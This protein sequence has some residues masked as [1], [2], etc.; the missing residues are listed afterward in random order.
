MPTWNAG[1]Y[2][3]FADER[4]RPCRD[5]VA[6][7]AL[8]S[9]RRIVDLGCGPGNSAAVLAARWPSSEII[10]V[11]S[12]EAMIAAARRSAPERT[13]LVDDIAS[14][15]ADTPFDLVFSNAA[16]QWIP[17]HEVAIPR[18]LAQAAPGGALAVQV[19]CNLHAAAHEAMRTIAARP[20][21]QPHLGGGVREWHV[22]PSSFYYDLL[23]PHAAR[24]DL[25]ETEHL[26]VMPGPSAIVEWYKGTGL[27]P[28]LDRLPDEAARQRFLDEYLEAITAAYP[29]RPDGRVLFAFRRLFVIAYR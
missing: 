8:E 4:T 11:D 14:W 6:A 18:L 24:L 3:R 21:W 5:L 19:P 7:L 9:P 29:A 22:H 28:F 2:L 23:A 10:G 17:D 27:R 15:T 25:W 12:S 20:T 16:L 1:Q 26:H 13:W